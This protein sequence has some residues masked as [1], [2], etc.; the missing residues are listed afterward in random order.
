[1][2]KILM[3]LMFTAVSISSQ[4]CIPMVFMMG[5]GMM[6]MGMMNDR[7]KMSM[8]PMMN[9]SMTRHHYVMKRGIPQVYTSTRPPLEKNPADVVAGKALYEK[10][11]ALCHGPK[12]FGDGVGGKALQPPP[13]NLAMSL[14]M[15]QAS[16]SF[17][18]WAIA[19]GGVMFN[20]AMPPFKDVLSKQ[21]IWQLITY[22]HSL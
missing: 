16:D 8:Q 1:M 2:N 11:C 20:T 6:G 19:E 9:M 3:T 15:P 5:G 21:E 10:H 18:T 7:D 14:K 22:L 13:T 4:A 17:I 12:G